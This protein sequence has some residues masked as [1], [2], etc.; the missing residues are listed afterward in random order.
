MQAAKS[1]RHK[2]PN[3]ITTDD[4]QSEIFTKQLKQLETVET[5]QL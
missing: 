3:S 2:Q 5:Q 4:A 1:G